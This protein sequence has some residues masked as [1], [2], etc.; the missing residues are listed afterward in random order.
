MKGKFGDFWSCG[1][2][3]ADGSWCKFKPPKPTTETEKFQETLDKSGAFMDKDKK[4]QTITRLALAKSLIESGLKHG[5]EAKNEFTWWLDL[6]EGRNPLENAPAS[7]L[8]DEEV[9][10]EGIHF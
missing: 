9:S 8:P 4:G 10:I 1:Q 6:V 2:K 5:L 3:N 7:S